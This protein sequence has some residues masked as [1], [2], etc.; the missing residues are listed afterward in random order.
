MEG[1]PEQP[2]APASEPLDRDFV[3]EREPISNEQAG[4]AYRAGNREVFNEWLT[5]RQEANDADNRD[6]R[7]RIILD[8]DLARIQRGAGAIADAI[9]RLAGDN[10]TADQINSHIYALTKDAERATDK[11]ARAAIIADIGRMEELQRGVELLIAE[12]AEGK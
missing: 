1:T 2:K 12:F 5:A 10:G 7:S 3:A 8:I 4:E 9:E 11:T 6:S